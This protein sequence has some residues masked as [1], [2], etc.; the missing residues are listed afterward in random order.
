M[1]HRLPVFD[2]TFI[3]M[4]DEI[5]SLGAVIGAS[6]AGAK[7]MTATSGPGFSLMQEQIGIACMAEVP[8]VIVN[9]MRVGPSTGYPTAPAQGDIQQARW[10]THGDHPI[11][12]LCPWSVREC[13]DLTV[14]AFN[15]SETYRVP[16]ILLMDEMIGHMRENIS[17]PEAGE[18]EVIDRIRPE[19]PQ[20]WY[21][22]YEETSSGV[23]AMGVFGEGYRYHVTGLVHDVRGFPTT[24]EDEVN[25]LM[26][27]LFRKISAHMKEIQTVETFGMEDAEIAVVAYGSTA[28][29][30]KRAVIMAREAGQKA[31]LLRL[32]SLW[33]FCRQAVE[34]ILDRCHVLVV[35]EMNFGQ[36]SR[37]VK[38]VVRDRTRVRVVNR[39]LGRLISP[40][41]ILAVM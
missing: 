27:R 23:P 37:E 32:I 33:P 25:A 12:A 11:I 5:G 29:A 38:R 17:I 20:E 21:I 36:V 28:R 26:N 40:E 2:G 10:G 9:V 18:L 31:G 34:S 15:L 14:R 16:V 1:A 8:C 39:I 24:R 7:G 4:E 3:Q 35:P 41:E 30:A 19:V 13:F 22:P 6:Q